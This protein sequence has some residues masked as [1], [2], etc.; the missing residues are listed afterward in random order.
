[1]GSYDRMKSGIQEPFQRPSGV[2]E[3]YNKAGKAEGRDATR[4]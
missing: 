2:S 1:M 3:E 4:W